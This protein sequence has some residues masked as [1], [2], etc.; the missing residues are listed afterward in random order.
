MKP[1]VKYF[2]LLLL[3]FGGYGAGAFLGFPPIDSEAGQGD[4]S[5]VSKFYKG[6]VQSKESAFQQKLKTDSTALNEA[7]FIAEVFSTKMFEF[8]DLVKLS[9]DVAGDIPEL[10]NEIEALKEVTILSN[11]ASKAGEVAMA[12]YNKLKTGEN[13]ELA[14]DVEQATQNLSLAYLLIDRQV[15]LGKNFVTATDNYLAKNAENENLALVRD[16]WAEYCVE[17]A[18][19]NGDKKE[20]AYWNGK[21]NLLDAQKAANS[22]HILSDKL[23]EMASYAYQFY[24]SDKF[25]NNLASQNTENTVSKIEEH[26]KFANKKS[27][28]FLA[29]QNVQQL[30]YVEGTKFLE[31]LTTKYGKAAKFD[32]QNIVMA[33]ELEKMAMAHTQ[34]MVSKTDPG[35]KRY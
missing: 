5:K 26:K 7:F 17:N 22:S 1:S 30:S 28:E 20:Y 13:S 2:S 18:I 4:V 29:S 27:Q 15:A 31:T 8:S 25:H 10:S 34:D 19:L 32:Q 23:Q 6:N 35:Q 16:M 12:S 9:V 24:I 11:N 14:T 3:F 21:S 33:R